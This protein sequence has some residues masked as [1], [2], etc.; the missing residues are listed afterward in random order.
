MKNY[1]I[2]GQDENILA[3]GQVKSLKQESRKILESLARHNGQY[4]KYGHKT[5]TAADLY[6]KY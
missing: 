6:G 3:V 5:Y 1:Q 4:V 2:I